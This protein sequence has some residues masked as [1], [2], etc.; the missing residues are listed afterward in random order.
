MSAART[1]TAAAAAVVL[2][3]SIP[4]PDTAPNP[5]LA[6]APTLESV[7]AAHSRPVPAPLFALASS[8]P[9]WLVT[10]R[11]R[12][13]LAVPLVLALLVTIG[14]VVAHRPRGPTAE[15]S[16]PAPKAGPP[17][18]VV[19]PSASP[20]PPAPA[21]VTPD[22]R[23]RIAAA[24]RPVAAQETAVPSGGLPKATGHAKAGTRSHAAHRTHRQKRH[25]ARPSRGKQTRL[26]AA[27]S[28]AAPKAGD[29]DRTARV[30]YERG[31]QRL[32]TGDTAA[33]ISAYQEAVQ[34]AP[35]S[36]SGYR[37][38]GLAYEKEGKIAEAVRAFRHYLKLAPR[39]GDRDLVARRLRHLL[40]P[41]GDPGK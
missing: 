28:A 17:P 26:A 41:G 39:S 21:K 35:G 37:G 6:F 20:V 13:R 7:A 1:Q 3:P 32:L 19:I 38:L 36:P 8:S 16:M 11:R 12:P 40:R 14:L 31:N 18:A 24:D 9:P 10:L 22:S 34:S 15:S 23:N 30:S 4:E 33:A 27:E 2:A 5:A 25:T 29:D